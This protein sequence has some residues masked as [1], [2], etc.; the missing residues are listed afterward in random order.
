MVSRVISSSAC[1]PAQSEGPDNLA[2]GS[3]AQLVTAK[4]V[5]QGMSN[6]YKKTLKKGS[7]NSSS[8]KAHSK[9]KINSFPH[10]NSGIILIMNPHEPEMGGVSVD[11]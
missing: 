7:N 5:S 8:L 9:I 3:L 10:T 1:T 4:Y 2:K 6:D 11:S